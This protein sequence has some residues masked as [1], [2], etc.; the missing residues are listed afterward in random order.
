MGSVLSELNQGFNQ[1]IVIKVRMCFLTLWIFRDDDQVFGFV[2]TPGFVFVLGFLGYADGVTE[3]FFKLYISPGWV[4]CGQRERGTSAAP[5][6][7][8]IRQIFMFS[9]VCLWS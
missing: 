9:T 5:R 6:F 8:L 1:K 4:C 2:K 3:S 7:V